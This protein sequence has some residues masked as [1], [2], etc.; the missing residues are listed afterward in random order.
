MTSWLS[1]MRHVLGP[2]VGR[3]L[4]GFRESRRDGKATVIMAFPME[5][6]WQCTGGE[7]SAAAA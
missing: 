7:R 2:W 5:R 6:S 1:V 4:C 3:I